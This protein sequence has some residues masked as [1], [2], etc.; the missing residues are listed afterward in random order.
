VAGSTLITQADLEARYPPQH[1]RALW[2]D[3]GSGQPGPRLQIALDVASRV[4]SS[5]LLKAW[6]DP[7]Q[8][9]ILA[10]EDPAVKDAICDLAMAHG[11]KGKPEWSGE[12]RPYSGLE[13]SA[14]DTHE[15]L[16][17]AQLRS[18]GEAKAGKNPNL[19]T[20]I[21]SPE[22]PAFMFAPSRGRPNPG[23]Y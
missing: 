2:S 21:A 16:A 4:A 8:H 13:K 5:I 11:A 14:K 22:E 10:D 3:T 15:H 9:V 19:Q 1:V 18:V 6:P 7:A 20:T 17:K 12:G 23:G